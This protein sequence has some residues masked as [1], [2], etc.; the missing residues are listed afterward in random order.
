MASSRSKDGI[1]QAMSDMMISGWAMLAD[2]CPSESCTGVRLN[3]SILWHIPHPTVAQIPLMRGRD[4]TIVC[5]KCD[6]TFVADDQGHIIPVEESQASSQPPTHAPA[7]NRTPASTPPSE[8]FV[9]QQLSATQ[10]S[11]PT[12]DS[13]PHPHS[14][15]TAPPPVDMYGLPPDAFARYASS[16]GSRRMGGKLLTGW[17]MLGEVC[18][19]PYCSCPIM[20]SPGGE[21]VCVNCPGWLPQEQRSHT[22]SAAVEVPP[23][24]PNERAEALHRYGEDSTSS[25]AAD[26]AS[27]GGML[28]SKFDGDSPV[29]GG[30][31]SFPAQ[32]PLDQPGGQEDWEDAMA[33]ISQG[34]AADEAQGPAARETVAQASGIV[35]HEAPSVASATPPPASDQRP[36]QPASG[37]AASGGQRLSSVAVLDAPADWSSMSHDE[38]MAFAAGGNAKP[39][40]SAAPK[41]TAPKPQPSA[42]APQKVQAPKVPPARVAVP[43]AA[44]VPTAEAPPVAASATAAAA[45]STQAAVSQQQTVPV[46]VEAARSALQRSIGQ[47]GAKLQRL[48]AADSPE[49]VASL[50]ACIQACAAALASLKSA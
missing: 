22:Y 12:Q 13:P 45:A 24:T 18:D 36:P 30:V 35:V 5:V 42:T 17:A 32:A 7:A 28:E 26:M 16:V 1:M 50:A 9:P 38:L 49:T 14:T 33:A 46:E 48:D 3:A 4:G 15:H 29:A 21:L 2:L 47:A 20:R 6:R 25:Q 43:A 39:A 11:A 27:S 19:S 34:I 31:S 10:R 41:L 37:G 44:A 8:G 23:P 40:P